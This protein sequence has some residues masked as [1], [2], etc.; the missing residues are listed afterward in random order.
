MDG[1]QWIGIAAGCCTATSLL[2]Q[3]FKTL[4]EK[5]AEDVSLV[6]LLV[7]MSGIILWIIY[8]IKRDDLPIMITNGFSLLV[9]LTMIFLR[10]RYKR[11]R[12]ET[13]PA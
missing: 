7:L 9:N 4:K 2:P 8:G 1:T 6:M 3:V 13:V 10:I 12:R 5:K 11:S